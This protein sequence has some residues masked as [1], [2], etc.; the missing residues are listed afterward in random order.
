MKE[1]KFQIGKQ[2]VTSGFLKS[3]Q[4][5]FTTHQR[6]RISVLR[7][8]A[9]NKKKV[10][11]FASNIIDQLPGHFSYKIIGFII[12]VMKHKKPR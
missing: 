5:A 8:S 2:G 1:A 4:L 9:P 12:L 3:L 6:A 11:S 7:N 10:Q